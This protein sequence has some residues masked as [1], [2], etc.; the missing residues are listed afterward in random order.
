MRKLEI[1]TRPTNTTPHNGKPLLMGT[2]QQSRWQE[3]SK[4]NKRFP[5]PLVMCKT[6]LV[7]KQAQFQG[8]VVAKKLATITTTPEQ[9]TDVMDED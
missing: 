3:Y 6:P 2:A 4:F 1:V 7:T 5:S 9:T 8:K